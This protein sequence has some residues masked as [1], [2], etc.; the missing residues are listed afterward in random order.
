MCLAI[1]NN[2]ALPPGSVRQGT[3]FGVRQVRTSRCR[4][5]NPAWHRYTSGSAQRTVLPTMVPP[6]TERLL[7]NPVWSCL[8][9]RHAHLALGGA[10]A[11][12]YP[13]AISPITGF[14]NNGPADVGALESLVDVG[15]D[16]GAVGPRVPELPSN[17][18]TLFE[19][20]VTQMIRAEHSPLPEGD[21]DVVILGEADVTD[22]LAL[23]ELTQPGPFRPRTIELGRF[24][25]IREGGRLLAM[26]GERMWVADCRE[27]SGICTHPD[28]QGR[29]Y[30]RALS[31]R[32]VN[33]MLAS[34]QL[35]ILHV[36]SSNTRAIGMYE[37]L[38]F[39]ARTEFPLLHARRL[40]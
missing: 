35:P 12:R 3:T 33:R 18:E 30:A 11:R 19:A 27:V 7:D 1:L 32:V 16:M 10:T 24:I 23:V 14:P 21:V 5:P 6:D 29:G 28:A 38:G 22:M 39:V 40:G 17:W 37:A 25:G 36:L 13:A 26:A 31:G 4:T 15:D 9:T 8:T 34:G 20:A 2:G